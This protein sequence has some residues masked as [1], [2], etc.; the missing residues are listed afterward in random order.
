MFKRMFK[1]ELSL[2]DQV[3]LMTCIIA[4]VFVII[5]LCLVNAFGMWAGWVFALGL[6]IGIGLL[7]MEMR[8]G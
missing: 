5:T 7:Y 3:T 4:A 2:D 1:R 6:A 8:M